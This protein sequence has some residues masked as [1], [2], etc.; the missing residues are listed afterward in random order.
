MVLINEIIG[1]FGKYHY[2]LCFI[3]FVNKCGVA[4]L[5]MSIIFL[6]PPVQFRCP[7]NNASCCDNPIYDRSKYTRTIVMEWNLICERAWLKDLTQTAFQFGVLVGSLAFGIASDKYGRR[8]TLTVS[9]IL[10]VFFG[11]MTS[12]LPDYWSFTAIRTVLGCAVGGIMVIGF[13]IVMEYVGNNCRDV[14]AALFHVPFTVGYMCL[15]LFGYFIRDYTY[16]LLAISLSNVVLLSY[17]CILPE[18]PRWLLAVNRTSEAIVLMERIAK[19]NDLPTNDIQNKIE[20]YQLEHK[21][22]SQKKGSLLDLFHFPYLRRNSLIMSFSWFACSYCF[23]GITLYLS[24]LTGDVYINVLASGSVCLAACIIIIPVTKFMNR[25]TVAIL[26]NVITSI[27][28]LSLAVVPEGK[29]SQVLG[30]IGVL[31]NYMNFVILYLYC[32]EMFP[33]VVRNAA[34]GLSSMMA[35]IGSMIA[36]FVAGFRPYGQW[37]APVAF[38]ILPLISAILCIFLPET[39]N[40]ELMMN[41]EEGEAFAKRKSRQWVR[42][43]ETVTAEQS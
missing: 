39:K 18:T 23:Y 29:A 13:V 8:I 19:V 9:V 41:M 21:S 7:D 31:F 20:M 32:S 16:F 1:S 37:C 11:V 22:N 10:E 43:S 38:G 24:H 42:V 2:F 28:L 30:I 33:T 14:V 35:R 26:T 15:T 3:I 27:C 25:K 34:I 4:F 36:P 17:I 5:Q 40:C 12:F 6:A